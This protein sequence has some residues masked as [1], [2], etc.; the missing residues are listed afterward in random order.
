VEEIPCKCELS[1]NETNLTWQPKKPPNN[2]SQC[3]KS[4][5]NYSLFNGSTTNEANL[6]RGIPEI[7]K[8]RDNLTSTVP[9][10]GKCQM[11]YSGYVENRPTPDSLPLGQEVVP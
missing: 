2:C 1:Y 5:T 9:G 4:L 8:Y 6:L 3:C 7:G 10:G 11:G